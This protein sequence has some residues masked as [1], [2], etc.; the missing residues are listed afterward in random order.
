MERG[1][2]PG[3]GAYQLYDKFKGGITISGIKNKKNIEITP[4][5]GA[6]DPESEGLRNRPCSAKIGTGLRS[7]I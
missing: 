5:P 7:K 4:G 3:P 6:Y 2:T 1:N